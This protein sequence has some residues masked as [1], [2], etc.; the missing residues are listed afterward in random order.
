ME[1]TKEQD[2]DVLLQRLAKAVKETKGGYKTTEFWLTIVAILISV[3]TLFV[4]PTSLAGK[5]VAAVGSVLA[6][7]GYGYHRAKVKQKNAEAAA[8]AAEKVACKAA[9]RL[10]FKDDDK[11]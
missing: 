2:V 3:A 4:D 11:E 5:I 10:L 1:P 7:L 8:K 9:T 6:A